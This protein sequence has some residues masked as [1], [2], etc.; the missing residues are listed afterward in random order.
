MIA[1]LVVIGNRSPLKYIYLIVLSSQVPF[2]EVNY[3]HF[4]PWMSEEKADCS[5]KWISLPI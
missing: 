2:L 3:A 4:L 5:I 1:I